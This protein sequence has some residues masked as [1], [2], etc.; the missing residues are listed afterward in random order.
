MLFGHHGVATATCIMYA[1]NLPAIILCGIHLLC[2]LLLFF[3]WICGCR[4]IG[5]ILM[6]IM[7]TINAI[8]LIMACIGVGATGYDNNLLNCYMKT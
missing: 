5:K 1:P 6:G 7:L 4:K 2:A 3:F 8:L